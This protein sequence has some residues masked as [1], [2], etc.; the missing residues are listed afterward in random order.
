MRHFF[1]IAFLLSLSC[2]CAWAAGPISIAVLPAENLTGGTNE[3]H[4]CYSIPSLVDSELG[5]NSHFQILPYQSVDYAQR[6]YHIVPGQRISIDLALKFGELIEAR[7][8]FLEDYER[9]NGVWILDCQIVNV[10]SG[11]AFPNINA[12]S[13]NLFQD[14]L[15]IR[16][17]LFKQLK[18][19]PTDE[20]KQRSSS[21]PTSS[22]EA[23]E[24]WSRANFCAR[25]IFSVPEIVNDLKKAISFDS[26]YAIAQQTLAHYL[27]FQGN[28]NE[29]LSLTTQCITNCPDDSQAH[30]ALAEVDIQENLMDL[31]EHELLDAVRLDPD[32]F[33]SYKKLAQLYAQR[34]DWGQMVSCLEKAES[35]S[36]Y[37][38][39]THA[40]LSIGYLHLSQ[41]KKA[42]TELKIAEAYN[43]AG[44][45]GNDQELAYAYQIMGEIPKAIDY[46]QKDVAEAKKTGMQPELYAQEETTINYLKSSL[47]PHFVSAT[48]PKSFNSSDLEHFAEQHLRQDELKLVVNP[49]TGTA[50]IYS[51]ADKLA[52]GAGDDMEKAR[53]LFAGMTH[54]ID[55]SQET[56]TK[57]AIDTFN[58]WPNLNAV[59]TCQDYTFLYIAMARHLGLQAYYV[60]VTRDFSGKYVS[61]ACA[62]LFIDG[63]AVLVDPAYLWFGVPHEEYEFE[64]D[65]RVMGL[66]LCE[67][68]DNSRVEAGLR[69]VP[70]WALPHFSMAISKVY[71]GEQLQARSILKEGLKYDSTSYLALFAEAIVEEGDKDWKAAEDHLRRCLGLNPDFPNSYYMLGHVL[72]AQ[73]KL[74]EARDDYRIYLQQGDSPQFGDD[75]RKA[76]EAIDESLSD[77]SHKSP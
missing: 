74:T 34:N 59:I 37:D 7:D 30:I 54:R 49:L 47:T 45:L 51:W 52:Q 77:T 36:P 2:S 26:R 15:G 33:K 44:S 60:L 69:L 10:P 29:A 41:Q 68:S 55:L 5:K 65:L 24:W 63:K 58:A 23:F 72:Q 40:E 4:W 22:F 27:L 67:F 73:G 42:M 13:T 66:Y 20:D 19:L 31:A 6:Y 17:G 61:H 71:S 46:Y 28:V 43:L 3:V 14:I 32:N 62:G 35:I 39:S 57:T 11:K 1:K 50:D 18:I 64:D 38:A 75:A 8:V 48:M 53:A 56:S 16:D 12:S 25:T 21:P 70:D 76:I 9:S